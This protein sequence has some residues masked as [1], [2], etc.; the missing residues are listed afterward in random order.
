M[1]RHGVVRNGELAGNVAGRQSRRARAHQQPEDQHDRHERQRP[2]RDRL[3]QTDRHARIAKPLVPA[4]R[5]GSSGF[6]RAGKPRPARYAARLGSKHHFRN[7][8]KIHEA[9]E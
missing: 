1:R 6:S 3:G 4:D 5:S 8:V 2:L 7:V 9:G